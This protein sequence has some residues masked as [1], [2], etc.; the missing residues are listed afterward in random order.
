MVTTQHKE[1]SF[2][3]GRKVISIFTQRNK[4]VRIPRDSE[5]GNP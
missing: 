2:V 1:L 3:E 5:K 4:H